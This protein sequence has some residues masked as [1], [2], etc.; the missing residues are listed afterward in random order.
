MKLKGK[1]LILA[2]LI[3]MAGS[4]LLPASCVSASETLE[5][6]PMEAIAQG[7][8]RN[9]DSPI[10][11]TVSCG[12]EGRSKSGRFMPIQVEMVN[13]KEEGFCGI[14]QITTL[15]TDNEIYE[16][17]YPVDIEGMETLVRE[18][19]VP[20]GWGQRLFVRVLD[21]N[22]REINRQVLELKTSSD[23][24]ELFIG[25]MA[26]DPESL[27]YLD[28]IGINY[29][30]IRTRLFSMTET[31]FPVDANGLDMLDILL[32]TDYDTSFLSS[33]Q[34]EAVWEW[35]KGGGTLLLGT[36]ER[37]DQVLAAFE[38]EI[39]AEDY[40]PA[41]LK[42]VNMGAEY[43]SEGPGDSS[44]E[45]MCTDVSLK[46]GSE[47]ISSDGF[48][49]LTSMAN[50][51]GTVAVAAFDFT[52]IKEFCENNRSYMDSFL[53][54]LLG[55]DKLS[56]ISSYIYN[57]NSNEYWTIQNILNS[58][59]VDKLPFLPLYVL[60][61]LAYL[62]LIGPGL[63]LFLKKRDKRNLYRTGVILL[64]VL[65]TVV[66][67]LMGMETR[68]KN[69]F[70]NYASIVD[71]S[72]QSVELYTYINIR[73]PYSRPYTVSLAPDYKLTP[74]TKSDFYTRP[75]PFHGG[76]TSDVKISFEDSAAKI[77]VEEATAFSP[78]YYSMKKS[79]PADKRGISG[80][81]SL[82]NGEIKGTLTNNYDFSLEK[83]GI[84]TGG[85]LLVIDEMDPSETVKLDN[86]PVITY[87]FNNFLMV[88]S[89]ITGRYQYKNADIENPDYMTALART[90]ILN[91]YLDQYYSDYNS[92]ARVVA[93]STEQ[94]GKDFLDD[95]VREDYETFGTT[96]YTAALDV[97]TE[98]DGY[99]YR[100]CL[101]KE[102]RIISGQYYASDNSGYGVEPIVLE[103]YLG[104]DIEVERLNFETPSE[105]FLDHDNTYYTNLFS[106]SISF[107]NHT[108]GSYELMDGEKESYTSEEL[109]PYLS[110]RNNITVQYVWEGSDE[111]NWYQTLPA[112]TVVGREKG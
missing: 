80:T 53:K 84:I 38:E 17:N 100:S 7:D 33:E 107:Y 1:T 25:V 67:Y 59:N 2:V 63:Y 65:F 70:F 43:A 39:V 112:L 35:V 22:D 16:Y 88:S 81:V 23:A 97:S 66:I 46:G 15:E 40:E 49:V 101:L 8:Y 69:V 87:P 75:S 73:T 93:F 103:Y 41:S 3:S 89:R 83:V 108:T 102:P 19:E 52:D 62:V 5:L 78:N 111:D 12:Y 29:S 32:I 85:K 106:G 26:D 94:E 77:A 31:E 14:L 54:E 90:N 110:P 68:F 55:D 20:S 9:P 24:A 18:L 21:S 60:V 109:E 58:G 76:E 34:V 104:N 11:L 42:S 28:N 105:E 10:A 44:I 45:L 74:I 50:G 61:V 13:E 95:E 36:G 37:A 51:T 82:F 86:L 92:Q 79:M 30:T 64:S 4:L 99:T 27:S 91:F 96:L 72:G 47:V 56:Q 6:E 57:G 48:P 71:S 98:R